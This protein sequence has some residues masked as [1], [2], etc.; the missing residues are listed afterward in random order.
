MHRGE[1]ERELAEK[2]LG[3]RGAYDE[4]VK[5]ASKEDVVRENP[6]DEDSGDD[7]AGR[8]PED[9]GDAESGKAPEGGS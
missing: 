2:E 9:E 6:A 3:P 1:E 5:Q 8:A 4:A 7:D